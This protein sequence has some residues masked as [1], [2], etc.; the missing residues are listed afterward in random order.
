MDRCVLHAARVDGGQLLLLFCSDVVLVGAYR[1][2]IGGDVGP[3]AF[4]HRANR[5]L[6]LKGG[7]QLAHQHHVEIAA[8][9][10]GHDLA[11]GHSTARNG[12]YQGV[13]V[14]IAFQ[15]VG[16]LMG[17]VIAVFEHGAASG[18]FIAGERAAPA[19]SGN[20]AHTAAHGT[21]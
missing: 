21:R 12:Q 11:D 17:S 20:R 1:G 5:H 3:A 15:A 18:G 6:W 7:A 2:S 10:P 9:L 4:R 16:Q 14:A 8:D 19:L 13:L